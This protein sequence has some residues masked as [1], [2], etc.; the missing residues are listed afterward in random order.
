MSAAHREYL[1]DDSYVIELARELGLLKLSPPMRA[2]LGVPVALV[3][4]DAS[5]NATAAATATATASTGGASTAGQ[6]A[7]NSRN[8]TRNA[9]TRAQ[10]SFNQSGVTR[11]SCLANLSVLDSGVL[12][13]LTTSGLVTK[14]DLLLSWIRGLAERNQLG[15]GYL[16]CNS[17]LG[18]Y[19][20]I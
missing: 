4:L 18:Q 2:A 20:S 9:T 15:R 11:V 10:L 17:F 19:T 13:L 1:L 3:L 6:D 8:N 12:Q 16:R 14:D 7:R 5:G